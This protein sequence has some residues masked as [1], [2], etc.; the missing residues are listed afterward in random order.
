MIKGICSKGDKTIFNEN[1]KCASN[2][3]ELY[4]IFCGYFSNIISELQFPSISENI[5]NVTDITDPLLA[6]IKKFQDHPSIKNIR[7]K[8]FKSVFSLT[9]TH[10]NEIEIKK[11]LE[12]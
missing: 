7:A 11:L 8:N 9:H 4:Q 5:S 2:D 6:A 1:D 3:D 10:T 12:A